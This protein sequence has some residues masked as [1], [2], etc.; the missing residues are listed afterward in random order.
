MHCHGKLPSE[1]A[2]EKAMYGMV[3][4]MWKKL[5]SRIW[6]YM[7]VN[8]WTV[9]SGYLQAGGS[10]FRA[11]RRLKSCFHRSTTYISMLLFH[12]CI[13]WEV[14]GEKSGGGERRGNTNIS[15]SAHPSS[16]N[17]EC[18]GSGGSFALSLHIT[19]DSE[20]CPDIYT[21]MPINDMLLCTS[22]EGLGLGL[23]WPSTLPVLT[24]QLS[25]ASFR[26]EGPWEEAGPERAGGKPRSH[27]ALPPR[28]SGYRPWMKVPIS[29]DHRGH[30]WHFFP[31]RLHL[32]H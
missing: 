31:S 17:Q 10:T 11:G 14:K 5:C 28:A 2:G 18:S 25:C 9:H 30:K 23:L 16:S 26:P 29:W 19:M 1:K 24:L 13:T 12:M 6:T 22:A 15:L 20:I 4:F 32:I 8:A 7:H 27:Q 21:S 3:P